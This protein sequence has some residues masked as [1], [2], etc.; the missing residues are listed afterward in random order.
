[1]LVCICNPTSDSEIIKLCKSGLIKS[2]SDL[3]DK[4]QICQN[5]KSCSKEIHKI[6]THNIKLNNY[7]SLH[8][9]G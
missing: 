2:E 1:M 8:S 6:Y 5:C 9:I 7:V 4:L 3:K